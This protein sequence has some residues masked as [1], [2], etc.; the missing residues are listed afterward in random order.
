MAPPS[1][2]LEPPANPVRFSV[3]MESVAGG[4]LKV[5]LPSGGADDEIGRM[6][7]ALTVFR[8]TAVDI[9]ENNLRE[10]GQARQR[11]LDAIESISEG[12]CYYDSKDRLVVANSRYRT[13][14]YP[15]AEA[16]AKNESAIFFLDISTS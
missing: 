2:G 11:L 3:C 5:R 8:D 15:G 14:M 10:I 16:T 6:V 12:F 4:D 1:Q 9:E 7:N 13:L